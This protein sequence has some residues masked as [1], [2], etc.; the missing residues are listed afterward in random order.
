VPPPDSANTTSALAALGAEKHTQTRTKK[1]QKNLGLRPKT[2]E[3][4]A[5]LNASASIRFCRAT[6]KLLYAADKPLNQN[7]HA[8]RNKTH[9]AF[10][11][12]QQ[13][14]LPLKDPSSEVQGR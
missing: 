10:A 12:E 3:V 2:H 4:P 14:R 8:M 11:N 1:A 9:G 5:A 6:F 7:P 13:K